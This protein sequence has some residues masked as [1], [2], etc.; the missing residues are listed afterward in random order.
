MMWSLTHY[1]FISVEEGGLNSVLFNALPVT[2]N[3]CCDYN[4]LSHI[5]NVVIGEYLDPA[6]SLCLLIASHGGGLVMFS[7]H[8]KACILSL[9]VTS[10]DKFPYVLGN[11]EYSAIQQLHTIIKHLLSYYVH[12]FSTT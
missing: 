7:Q 11:L 4:W 5:M 9:C 1:G 3:D 10:T 12:S 6:A 8:L 2:V